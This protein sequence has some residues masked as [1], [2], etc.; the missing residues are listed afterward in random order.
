VV[1]PAHNEEDTIGDCVHALL[2]QTVPPLEILVVD[3]RST[4]R[5]KERVQ[6][7]AVEYPDA[8][9]RLLKQDEAIGLIPT[10]NAGFEAARGAVLARIDADTIVDPDW[11]ANIQVAMSR[12]NTAAITGP[13]RYYD[14]PM[15]SWSAGL[16]H[17]TR[18]LLLSVL[19]KTTFLFG[20]NMAL[21]RSAWSVIRDT[22]CLDSDDRFHEDIDLALH[23][24]EA[25]LPVRYGSTMRAGISARRLADSP[26][27]FAEYTRRFDRTCAA[28]DHRGTGLLVAG[29][30]LRFAHPAL[31]RMYAAASSPRRAVRRFV[32]SN[33][34]V[35]M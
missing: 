28:H 31:R 27:D 25:G 15:S 11:I 9:I 32:P 16:D 5:T 19:P 21:R 7:I 33:E 1:V 6:A 17:L 8:N 12:S 18:T 35:M 34:L 23:L 3:N 10:R 24:K 13:V 2:T 29:A 26:V 22:T 4:D 14:M 30:L 20:S